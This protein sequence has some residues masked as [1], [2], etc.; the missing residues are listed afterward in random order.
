M[1]DLVGKI[2]PYF[3]QTILMRGWDYYIHHAVDEF[4]YFDEECVTATVYG[5]EPYE[6]E[7]NLRHFT[8]S[9]CDCPYDGYCK[10]M[11][12]V[13]FEACE[14]FLEEDPR[15]LLSPA[16]V[17]KSGQAD[18][19]SPALA[20]IKS[21]DNPEAWHKFFEKQTIAYDNMYSFRDYSNIFMKK[22]LPI[23]SKWPETER[24]FYELNAVLFAMKKVDDHI[25][26]LFQIYHYDRYSY[27]DH[28]RQSSI[29]LLNHMQVIM[30][31]LKETKAL[32]SDTNKLSGTIDYLALLAFPSQK[33]Y[34]HWREAYVL[35]WSAFP[36]ESEWVGKERERIADRINRGGASAEE[37]DACLLAQMFFL[38]QKE[39]DREAMTLASDRM[40]RLQIKSFFIYLNSF[41]ERNQWDRL[42]AWLE[43]LMPAAK[44]SY[45]ELDAYLHYWE[46]LVTAL[47]DQEQ[48]I[49]PVAVALLPRSYHYYSGYLL[50]RKKYDEWADLNIICGVSPLQIDK[51]DYKQVESENIR[52]LLP[53]YHHAVEHLIMEKKRDSYKMAVRHLKKMD[54]LYRKLKQQERWMQYMAGLRKRYSRL[55]AF[56]EE[57]KKGKWTG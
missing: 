42:K 21:T 27:G 13:L 18:K 8:R 29:D 50:D 14:S 19:S 36:L 11:A 37:L 39:E 25:A 34:V 48:A 3:G 49:K 54:V 56:Q 55:R 1:D 28:Y 51:A 46:Q 41:A 4:M 22:L 12:A 31:R 32:E 6:V 38:I 30:D 20:A 16:P 47:P 17:E 15:Y 26:H 35:F 7:L 43:W 57:L 52:Y 2:R 33:S 44:Q 53:L 9:M 5:S 24:L 40:N 45:Q 23:G 10:H